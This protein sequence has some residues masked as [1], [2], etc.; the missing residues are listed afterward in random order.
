MIPDT[1]RAH[2]LL[3]GKIYDC[4][5][6]PGL[7]PSVL[8]DITRRYEGVIATMA[9]LEPQTNEARFATAFGDPTIIEPLVTTYAPDMPFYSVIPRMELDVPVTM[10]TIYDMHGPGAREL[11]LQ[12]RL[13]REWFKPNR[14]ADALCLAIVKQNTR[15]GTLV[16]TTGEDRT[17][18]TQGQLDD[19][20]L[21]AP[22]IRR[23]V[24][25]GDLFGTRLNEGEVY[26]EILDELA[27]ALFVVSADMRL[28]YANASAED[29]LR[30][31]ELAG[32]PSGRLAFTNAMAQASIARCVAQSE[33]NEFALGPRGIN[34]PVGQVQHSAVAHVLPLQRRSSAGRVGDGA[35]AIFIAEAGMDP[36]PAIEALSALFGLTPA[37]K[38]VATHIAQGR[39]RAEIA[40]AQGVS[41]GT[42]KS[43]LDSIFGKTETGN[44]RDLQ[45]LIRDLTPPLRSR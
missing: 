11:M 40:V 43:Q 17:A 41:D 7:W 32:A 25:I 36:L 13:G 18:I 9:V 26:K 22:H 10:D 2:S 8:G 37:E 16:I 39:T 19:L 44:Q 27:N 29:I 42:V 1:L 31:G 35:A 30:H 33:R 38:R 15:V 5:A 3:V 6:E 24:M 21:V 45:N 20:G 34:L 28:L 12:T 14:L 23:A 4:V